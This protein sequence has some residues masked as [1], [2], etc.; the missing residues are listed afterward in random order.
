MF[1]ALGNGLLSKT[2]APT[3]KIMSLHICKTNIEDDILKPKT[4]LAFTLFWNTV[5]HLELFYLTFLNII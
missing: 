3:A 1:N 5:S 2:H 4:S